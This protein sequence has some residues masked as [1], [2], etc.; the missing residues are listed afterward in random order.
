MNPIIHRRFASIARKPMELLVQLWCPLEDSPY[1]R[2]LYV[3]GCARGSCQGKDD[4]S[5]RAWRALRFNEKYAAKLEKKRARQKAKEDAKKAAQKAEE[6]RK[7][8]AKVNPFSMKSSAG[9]PSFGMG[10]GNQIFGNVSA[11]GPEDE[12]DEPSSAADDDS[13]SEDEDSS[14]SEDELVTA[15]ASSTLD[16][17]EWATAPAYTSLYLSTFSEYLPKQKTPK[18]PS[19]DDVEAEHENGKQPKDV[20]WAME[21]YENSL[22][23]D[24]VFDRFSQR[25]EYQSDQCVRYDMGGTPLPFA[26][27]AVFDRLF[28]VPRSA[29][30]GVPVT[31]AAFM[32]TPG[33]GKRVFDSSSLPACKHCGAKRVFEC[34][35]MPNLINVLKTPKSDEGKKNLTDDERRKEVEKVLK[36]AG[37]GRMDWGTCMIFSCEKDCEA[38]KSCWAEE[39]VLVQWDS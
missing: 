27:D 38:S 13:S 7:S 11:D 6:E 36:R 1:D 21:G 16:T 31:K 4:G 32:V 24:H 12:Q 8:S 33:G 22:E 3:W 37:D 35:L 29:S 28:P 2:V 26:H 9:A 15:M 34:Q 19:A 23:T 18:V 20:S 5:V 30:S 14:G 25:V 39:L 17:S 10:L